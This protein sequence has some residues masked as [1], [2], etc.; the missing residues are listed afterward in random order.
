MARPR[1][2]YEKIPPIRYSARG[3]RNGTAGIRM[4]G[5]RV[6]LSF[7]DCDML[8]KIAMRSRILINERPGPRGTNAESHVKEYNE[9]VV[10]CYAMQYK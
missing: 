9:M 1:S 6:V 4:G 5:V 2:D 3:H 7:G 10:L 8:R